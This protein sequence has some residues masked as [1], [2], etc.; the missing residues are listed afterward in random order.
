MKKETTMNRILWKLF[1]KTMAATWQRGFQKGV[2]HGEGNE[3]LAVHRRLQKHDLSD[4]GKSSLTLGYH[5]A[6]RAALDE[7][8]I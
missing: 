6:M 3:R 7:I 5:T 8:N 1:P 4:M 2:K